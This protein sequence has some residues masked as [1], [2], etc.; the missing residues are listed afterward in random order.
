MT[1]AFEKLYIT[2]KGILIQVLNIKHNTKVSKTAVK[3]SDF[4][5]FYLFDAAFLGPFII[6]VVGF[7]FHINS[8]RP[9]GC[10]YTAISPTGG[11]GGTASTKVNI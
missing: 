5:L 6:L 9:Q 8:H 10:V 4:N 11:G 2:K 7:R 3:D 1:Y